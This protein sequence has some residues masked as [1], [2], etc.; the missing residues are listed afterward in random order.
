MKC[1]VNW[2]PLNSTCVSTKLNPTFK[3]SRN[4]SNQ[5]SQNKYFLS[6]FGREKSDLAA[7]R[8]TM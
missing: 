2:I 6:N 4:L 3:L 5:F 1:F 7:K 8:D